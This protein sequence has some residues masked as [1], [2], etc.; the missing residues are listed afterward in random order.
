MPLGIMMVVEGARFSTTL[1]TLHPT[2]TSAIVHMQP[3]FPSST[4]AMLTLTADGSHPEGRSVRMRCSAPCG[5]E[6]S[7]FAG[8]RREAKEVHRLR[9]G[10]KS[11][12]LELSIE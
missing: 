1:L 3:S 8:E 9:L 11:V 6:P 2:P 7:P 12:V 5:F 4:H 10:G